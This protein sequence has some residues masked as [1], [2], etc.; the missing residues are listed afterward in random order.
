MS[1]RTT[2]LTQCL[3]EDPANL[4]YLQHFL[5]NLAQKY[6][7]NKKGAR[8]AGL[9]S[10]TSRMALSKAAGKGQW[11]DAFAAACEAL[12]SNPWDTATLLD[13]ADAYQRAWQR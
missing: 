13:V 10:K 8:F 3:T 4:I 11:R 5:G 9:K 12:K 1:M 2:C 6:G 7:N